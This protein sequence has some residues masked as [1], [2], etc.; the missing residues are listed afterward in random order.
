M[1]TL[2]IDE[3]CRLGVEWV[4]PNDFALRLNTSQFRLISKVWAS[5][6]VKTLETASNQIG[7]IVKWFLGLLVVL[8]RELI[9]VSKLI[10]RNIK[11][12]ANSPQR[13]RGHFCMI[14]K[15]CRIDG[16]LTH[17]KGEMINLM[18]QINKKA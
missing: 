6:F 2:M 10:S 1:Y 13:A 16:V 9:D 18:A 4:I 5:F 15:S 14:N 8:H 17:Q 3:F 11:C 7:F 12:M